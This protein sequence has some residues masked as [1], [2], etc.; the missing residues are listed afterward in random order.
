MN[1]LI[2]SPRPHLLTQAILAA[3]DDYE[4]SME[5]PSKWPDNIDFVVSFGYR[6]IIKGDRLKEYE[7]RMLNMH[8]SWLPWNRGADPNFWSWFDHTPKGISIHAIDAGIDTGDVVAQMSIDKWREQETLRTSYDFLTECAGR[9]F[10][11]EW[12]R[13]R[14]RDWAPLPKWSH[15]TYHNS[16]DKNKWMEKLPL[17]HDSPVADVERLGAYHYGH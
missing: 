5:P 16:S 7:D 15:G 14:E 6:H 12:E 13:L 1:V 8:I 3:G 11:L 4:V 2:L 10:N 9:L 17:G